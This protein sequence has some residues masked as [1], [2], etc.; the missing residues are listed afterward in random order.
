M[1]KYRWSQS[2]GP[3]GQNILKP[4][5]DLAAGEEGAAGDCDCSQRAAVS[6]GTET[7]TSESYYAVDHKKKYL[8]IGKQCSCSV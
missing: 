6:N 8:E 1:S 3:A 5:H 7:N 4:A 2:D